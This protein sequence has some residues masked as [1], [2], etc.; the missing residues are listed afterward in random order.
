MSQRLDWCRT[1]IEWINV[2][3]Q[4]EEKVNGTDHDTRPF[5][6]VFP[7]DLPFPQVM[8]YLSQPESER[9]LYERLDCGYSATIVGT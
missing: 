8:G 1:S 5:D 2:V 6:S 9:Y 7:R 3:I 4:E